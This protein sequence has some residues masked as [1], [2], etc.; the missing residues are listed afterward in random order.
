MNRGIVIGIVAFVLLALLG[1]GIGGYTLYRA[2]RPLHEVRIHVDRAATAHENEVMVLEPIEH[3]IAQ[4]D[5]MKRITGTAT[6]SAV[7]VSIFFPAADRTTEDRTLEHLRAYLKSAERGL[8][9]GMAPPLVTALP[10]TEKYFVRAREAAPLATL[11]G[12]AG[13]ETCGKPMPERAVVRLDLGKLAGAGIDL[14][15][16][17]TA[18][19]PRHPFTRGPAVDVTE[20]G[21]V[22][23]R[24]TPTPV[25]LRDVATITTAARRPDCDVFSLDGQPTVYQLVDV[26]KEH[27][28]PFLQQT[29]VLGVN[30]LK[31]A[32]ALRITLRFP[33]G[34]AR[35]ERLRLML[36]L[37]PT[38]RDVEGLTLHGA[39]LR[40]SSGEVVFAA[41]KTAKPASVDALR[42]GVAKMPGI[43]WGGARGPLAKAIH[44][45][46]VVVK[47]G[48]VGDLDALERAAQEVRA[49]VEREPGI[50]A[51]VGWPPGLVPQRRIVA[52]P[53][54][55]TPEDATWLEKL[56]DEDETSAIAIVAPELL[57]DGRLHGKPLAA[58]ATLQQSG[59]LAFFRHEDLERAIELVWETTDASIAKRVTK[60]FAGDRNVIVT[61]E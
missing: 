50:G 61:L 45:L 22:L 15:E 18:L 16:V 7:D 25:A 21:M 60:A 19:A 5:G 37:L 43:V 55:L 38:L 41:A 44:R 24:G 54:K 59:E 1:A 14:G 30:V 51:A 52:T 42:D 56:L 49:R 48:L 57:R 35:P 27:E 3:A 20:L 36:A 26:V 28:A 34:L 10:P 40:A 32:D 17:K 23:L 33:E 2:R 53:G 9:A 8:P 11:S 46:H 12:V 39:V 58:L 13:V 4:T 29:K 6:P 31:E 47:D